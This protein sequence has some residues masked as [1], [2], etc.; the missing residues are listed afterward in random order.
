MKTRILLIVCLA[1]LLGSSA[2]GP[3]AAYDEWLWALNWNIMVPQ[4]KTSDYIK[5]TSYRGMSLEGRKWHGDNLTLG[6][7]FGW[8][9]LDQKLYTTQN[10]QGPNASVD[11]TGTQYR[12]INT[13]PVLAGVHYYLGHWGGSR[14]FFGAMG[15]GYV[16]ERRV[17]LGL[18]AVES[19]KWQ[20]G[21]APEV[22]LLVPFESSVGFVSVRYNYAFENGSDHPDH[23]YWSAQIGL[24]WN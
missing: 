14:L 2:A 11:I 23:I 10:V 8:N 4:D 12:Y 17:E 9:V 7:M 6:F 13:F 21:A 18:F 22:G 20:W 5:D 19:Q 1:T 15:G 16:V 24:G 3:A